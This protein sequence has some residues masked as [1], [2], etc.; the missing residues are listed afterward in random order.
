MKLVEL[1]PKWIG[2]GDHGEIL[3]GLRFDCPHCRVQR[4]CVLFTPFIDPKNWL[5]IIGGEFHNDKQKWQRTGE[6]FETIT[7]RPSIN[8]EFAGHWHGHIE[9]GEIK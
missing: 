9:N 8:T 1:N 3:F 2:A 4:L 6:T 7:L 5:P